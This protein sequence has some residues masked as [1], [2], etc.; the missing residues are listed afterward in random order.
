MCSSC[1]SFENRIL[2]MTFC[3]CSCVPFHHCSNWTMNPTSWMKMKMSMC[4]S[5]SAWVSPRPVSSSFSFSS[6]NPSSLSP[7][8]PIVLDQSTG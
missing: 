3:D 5:S 7:A 1:V 8:V 6:P 4:P 2:K